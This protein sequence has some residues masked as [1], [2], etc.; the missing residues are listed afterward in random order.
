MAIKM[1]KFIIRVKVMYKFIRNLV[2]VD[3]YTIITFVVIVIENFIIMAKINISI[4]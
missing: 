3:K 1:F 4:S 2:R